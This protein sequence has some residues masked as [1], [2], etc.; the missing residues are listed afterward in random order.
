MQPR[1][2]PKILVELDSN[3]EFAG[4]IKIG[5]DHFSHH[6]LI[7]RD[8][9]PSTTLSGGRFPKK[10]KKEKEMRPGN[11]FGNKKGCYGVLH[12]IVILLLLLNVFI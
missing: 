12:F 9:C 11:L 4:P 6:W 3:R 7:N 8:I 1:T 5:L 10:K 2:D